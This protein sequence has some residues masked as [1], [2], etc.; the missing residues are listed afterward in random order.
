MSH[1]QAKDRGGS[2]RVVTIVIITHPL[3]TF[4][5]ERLLLSIVPP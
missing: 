3:M 1:S 5:I 4:C 2:S